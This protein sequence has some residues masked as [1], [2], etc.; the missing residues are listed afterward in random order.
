MATIPR[1]FAQVGG[2]QPR[3]FAPFPYFSPER[4][5]AAARQ[6]GDAMARLGGQMQ[7]IGFRLLKQEVEERREEQLS[8]ALVGSTEELADAR[9][10]LRRD[11]DYAGR[12]G[13]FTERAAT[14]YQ[15]YGVGMDQVAAKR[16]RRRFDGLVQ[17]QR[18]SIKY[19]AQTEEIAAA[20][21]QLASGSDKLLTLALAAE[22]P[23]ER[24]LL[25]DQVNDN[26]S[27]HEASGL[28]DAPAAARFRA[29]AFGGFQRAIAERRI[30]E[31]PAAA[32]RE[33]DNPKNFKDLDPFVRE[34]L[35]IAARRAVRTEARAAR[36]GLM[37]EIKAWRETRNRGHEAAGEPEL[38]AK[39]KAFDPALADRLE[40]ERKFYS[41]AEGFAKATP[42][43]QQRILDT[44]FGGALTGEQSG[45]RAVLERIAA[46][47]ARETEIE[48]GRLQRE[49]EADLLAAR[50]NAEESAAVALG[51][52]GQDAQKLAEDIRGWRDTRRRGD[53]YAGEGALFERVQQFSPEL[54]RALA[55]ER[56]FFGRAERFR[57]LTP[58]EQRRMLGLGASEL[59]PEESARR[60]VM[61]KIHARSVEQFRRDPVAYIASRND[62]LKVRYDRFRTVEAALASAP[63][64]PA[65]RGAFETARRD[66][67]EA[68]LDAQKAAGVPS[69]D[70]RV[71]PL[72]SARRIADS[73]TRSAPAGVVQQ[74]Q[75]LAQRYGEYW[76]RV[77]REIARAGKLPSAYRTIAGM[78]RPG[79][80]TQAV[81][82][83][84]AVEAGEKALTDIA[85]KEDVEA[86]DRQVTSELD[87]FRS[88]L[89]R[90]PGGQQGYL[91]IHK[92]SRLLALKYLA[93]GEDAGAAA[94]KAVAAIYA[95]HYAEQRQGESQYRVPVEALATLDPAPANAVR[96]IRRGVRI[97]MGAGLDAAFRRGQI[98]TRHIRPQSTTQTAAEVAA[99]YRKHLQRYGRWVTSRDETGVLLTDGQ[100]QVVRRRDGSPYYFSWESLAGAGPLEEMSRPTPNGA[101]PP[102]PPSVPAPGAAD[103]FDFGGTDDPSA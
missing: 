60:E 58:V 11:P 73:L 103:D 44:R 71:L 32:A 66:A 50:A 87:G 78:T 65:L 40:R 14:I 101:P 61:Q 75:A 67:I 64:D 7:Q 4:R 93:M 34:R 85:A 12:A 18:I 27:R 98:E 55:E 80:G 81:L 68:M 36:V 48:M 74:S 95:D 35:K 51:R 52:Q 45:R 84:E 22:N 92:A 3:G 5:A 33:L 37:A 28:L 41:D 25:L 53:R 96:K 69:V 70:R 29:R 2:G 15:K 1:H 20:Q 56:D 83:A 100:G 86:V 63:D 9:L 46:R 102:P 26:I 72:A 10:E 89:S 47:T 49:L 23:A 59:T 77:Y 54:H 24:A 16:F 42:F 88:E 38:F 39:V 6:D 43:E 8:K 99:Q 82:L 21:A 90:L 57:R 97:A 17:S 30:A 31:N 79:Q 62:S 91:E 76:P 13:K 94:E 19:R